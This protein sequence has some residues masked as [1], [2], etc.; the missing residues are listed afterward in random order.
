MKSL[1]AGLLCLLPIEVSLSEDIPPSPAVIRHS[2]WSQ[3][4]PDLAVLEKRPMGTI[5]HVSIHHTE[6]PVPDT[7][8]EEQRLRNIQEYHQTTQGWGDVAYHYL[9]GPS[10]KVYEGRSER[11]AASSG[12]I[13]LTKEQWEAAPQDGAGGTRASKPL[14]A[15]KP[16]HSGGHLTVCFV[17]SY[18]NALPTEAARRAA[19]ALVAR[20]LAEN[21]LTADDV[22]FHRE[23]ALST[24]CPG[25]ALYDWFRG[26]ARK[27]GA[28]GPGL[29]AIAAELSR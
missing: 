1:L 14:A 19:V 5:R 20:K 23:I 29:D 7:V 27:R 21:H 25:Q 15:V 2:S 28:R 10:G 26:P 22:F 6:T 4:Q 16:G 18:G 3:V 17:G 12:T 9:V 13:Y 8:L 11:F 24:D